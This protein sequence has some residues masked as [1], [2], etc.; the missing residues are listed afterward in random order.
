MNVLQHSIHEG[1]GLI[2]EWAENNGYEVNVYQAA[3][4]NVKL[5]EV[6]DTDMLV[7]LGGPM[8]VNDDEEWI[9][10]ERELIRGM[11]MAHK[12]YL[13]ICFGAQQLSKTLG[14][15]VSS[16][17]K[18]V[19][20]GEVKRLSNII[21]GVPEKLDVLHWHGEQFRLPTEATPLFSS[22][23]VENQGFIINENA[24]G[25]QFHL[26]MNEAGV[27]EVVENDSK[28]IKGNKL[29]QSAADILKHKIPEM[30]KQALF[31]MLDYI[32]D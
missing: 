10:K 31:A 13:G 30:N 29:K 22:P 18:E 2:G 9:V 23:L 21:P 1:I 3:N 8:S 20:W 7:V 19:G 26:E 28:F 5:P 6:I 25:L 16:C 12:S 27:R 24:I 32:K 15:D 17:P 11:L 14:G 4:N